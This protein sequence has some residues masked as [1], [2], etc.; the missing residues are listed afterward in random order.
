MKKQ[1]ANKDEKK[2]KKRGRGSLVTF[3]S[4]TT[5]SKLIGVM[6][7]IIQRTISKEVQEAKIFSVEIDTTQDV[8]CQDQCSIVLR[9]AHKGVVLERLLLRRICQDST[10]VCKHV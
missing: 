8:S 2:S 1:S 7:D 10:K 9:Y 5:I 6:K 4:K 3:M